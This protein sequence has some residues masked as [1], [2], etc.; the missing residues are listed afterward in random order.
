MEKKS[1]K[2]F[3]YFSTCI[4]TSDNKVKGKLYIENDL[5]IDFNKEKVY[6]DQKPHT[7]TERVRDCLFATIA[8]HPNVALYDSE[9]F[10]QATEKSTIIGGSHD[11]RSIDKRLGF[12]I[13]NCRAI[14][15]HC[16]IPE[17]IRFF[18]SENDFANKTLSD[19][20]ILNILADAGIKENLLSSLSE[21]F[22]I[23]EKYIEE[24]DPI[25]N[26][27]Y[28]KNKATI[29][30]DSK[31]FLGSFY[32]ALKTIEY[33]TSFESFIKHILYFG[34]QSK[35]LSD[36]VLENY[37]RL[38]IF[39][40]SL[41]N[42][43]GP[44]N[45]YSDSASKIIEYYKTS[46]FDEYQMDQKIES[47]TFLNLIYKIFKNIYVDNTLTV[48]AHNNISVEGIKRL[49]TYL[50][51]K[52]NENSVRD[53]ARDDFANII[54]SVIFFISHGYI[55]KKFSESINGLSA[56]REEFDREVLSKYGCSGTPGIYA[57]HRLATRE[58]PNAIAVFEA[59]ELEYYGK[60]I[61]S[62]PNY[63]KAFALY[64]KGCYHLKNFNPMTAWSY[65]YM[66][67]NYRQKDLEGVNIEK[68][69][70]LSV[71]KRKIKAIKP[72]L[73]AFECGCPA[74]ANILG[75]IV[76]DPE[77]PKKEKSHLKKTSIE[78]YEIA[79]SEGYV[80]SKNRLSKYWETEA[81]KATTE[82][83][84]EECLK[85]SR[86]YLKESA[87]LGE[88]YA[89]NKYASIYLVDS[90]ENLQ[91]AFN[92]FLTAYNLGNVKT[93]EWAAANLIQ[94]YITP[95]N[96]FTNKILLENGID[97]KGKK[98]FCDEL[99]SICDKS[100]DEKIK[101]ILKDFREKDM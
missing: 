75:Q 96:E 77:I 25:T 67:Y 78:Y 69:N 27:P 45:E 74:A 38:D 20:D 18:K 8:S 60:G 23:C 41:L 15:Y 58:N 101:A 76:E 62:T 21:Y 7:L 49:S 5:Y 70:S 40:P 22:S 28:Q 2:E 53:L 30:S 98:K 66:L 89:C 1:N 10:P 99:E 91:K 57:I 19:D 63:E 51:N 55:C 35:A 24:K 82:S 13:E 68:L 93:R 31:G 52:K 71:K 100:K 50:F 17:S 95:N 80:F 85:K 11:L 44:F 64:K 79:S 37:Q 12:L 97:E 6:I 43:N 4:I 65:A 46:L 14:G 88:P 84:R 72:A 3:Y 87:E 56:D 92:Y 42:D 83:E 36:E 81:S 54:Y 59:A 33:E 61:S 73:M 94:Y 16:N 39:E 86:V 47:S 34:D 29:S 26:K 48:Y 32:E 9:Y 90:P